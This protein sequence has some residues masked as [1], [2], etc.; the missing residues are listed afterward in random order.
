VINCSYPLITEKRIAMEEIQPAHQNPVDVFTNLLT[1]VAMRIMVREGHGS[2]MV[3]HSDFSLD[4]EQLPESFQALIHLMDKTFCL[5]GP[6]KL[7]GPAF[8]LNFDLK[9]PKQLVVIRQLRQMLALDRVPS[10]FSLASVVFFK[11]NKKIALQPSNNELMQRL[12]RAILPNGDISTVNTWFSH[13]FQNES[14]N[15][16]HYYNPLWA[17]HFPELYVLNDTH[18]F[19]RRANVDGCFPSPRTNARRI[20]GVLCSSQAGGGRPATDLIYVMSDGEFA[21]CLM[22]VLLEG[23]NEQVKTLIKL[24]A[25]TLPVSG[26]KAYGVLKKIYEFNTLPVSPLLLLCLRN[27]F[28]EEIFNEVY[29]EVHLSRVFQLHE[30]I[31]C[32]AAACYHGNFAMFNWL[33]EKGEKLDHD[34]VFLLDHAIRGGQEKMCESLVQDFNCKLGN[35]RFLYDHFTPELDRFLLSKRAMT[36]QQVTEL[37][38]FAQNRLLSGGALSDN[39]KACIQHLDIR[40]GD[41]KYGMMA[42]V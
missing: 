5:S 12:Q 37:V 6:L 34:N 16:T 42:L 14:E 40:R 35:V 38:V 9:D 19:Y 20:L 13:S 29:N 41:S 8:Y 36:S 1:N 25:E 3:G 4:L 22:A 17:A 15:E 10:L 24:Y 26:L 2:C 33:R 27:I 39:Q 30:P 31:T 18:W 28:D 11:T 32:L 7:I 21:D 23:S